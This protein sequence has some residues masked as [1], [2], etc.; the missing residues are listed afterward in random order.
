LGNWYK[1]LT[2]HGQINQGEEMTFSDD[3]I[4]RFLPKDL[5]RKSS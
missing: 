2:K 4:E 1:S 5:R 3:E